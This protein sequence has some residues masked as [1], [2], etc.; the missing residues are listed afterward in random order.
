MVKRSTY[1]SENDISDLDGAFAPTKG[2]QSVDYDTT[3]EKIGLTQAFGAVVPEELPY[4]RNDETKWENYDWDSY[5]A[6]DDPAEGASA[7][8]ASEQAEPAPADEAEPPAAPEEVSDAGQTGSRSDAKPSGSSSKRGR[9]AAPEVSATPRM[10]RSRRTR[11][12]LIVFIILLIIAA[13]VFGFFIYK[14]FTESQQQAA[15]QVQEKVNQSDTAQID[16]S[17]ADDSATQQTAKL[18]DVPDITQ[19]LGMKQDDAVNALKRGAKI[20]GA[21]A[22]GEDEGAIKT[23]VTVALLDEPADPRTG[24]TPTVYLGLNEEGVVV[25]AGY[26]ASASALGFGSLSFADAVNNEH[27]IEKTLQKVGVEVPEGTVVLP[28]NR[29]SYSTYATDGTTVTKERC[30]FAG[31]ATVNGQPCTWSAVLSYDYTTQVLTGNLSDTVRII[32]VYV[33]T[34]AAS[35]PAAA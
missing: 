2:L 31:D 26:S 15:Q 3:D 7:E 28:A 5:S 27:V 33:T 24:G 35:A 34:P 1:N 12:V 32:Y 6:E 17:K 20:T 9:H 4:G 22:A 11:R 19:I 8:G 25:Q 18:A 21:S 30:S 23:N 29:D 14:G 13:G 16:D 10:R